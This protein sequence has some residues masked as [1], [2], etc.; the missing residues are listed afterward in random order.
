MREQVLEFHLHKLERAYL[1]TPSA[2]RAGMRR[3]ILTM[4][5]S[6]KASNRSLPLSLRRLER[7]MQ[8][9]DDDDFFDNMPV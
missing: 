3:G 8:D 6:I 2:S 9:E 5:R 4:I 1:E 7:R